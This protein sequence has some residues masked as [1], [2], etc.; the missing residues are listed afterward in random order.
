MM[1]NK[2]KLRTVCI[3]EL[4]L[5]IL[6]DTDL[7][8]MK[9]EGVSNFTFLSNFTSDFLCYYIL[10]SCCDN[11]YNSHIVL[12]NDTSHN[13]LI[14]VLFK[15]F[16]HSSVGKESTCNAG[17]PGSIP[18][19]GRFTGEG[20][21]YPLQ[22]SWASPVAQLV[23]NLPAVQETRVQSLGQEDP[24]EKGMVT[25]SSILAWRIRYTEDPGGLKSMGSQRIGRDWVTNASL[26]TGLRFIFKQLYQEGPWG[27]C[28][29]S[30]FRLENICMLPLCLS[31]MLT[32]FPV[33]LKFFLQDASH[34]SPT[35]C[36][37]CCCR[38][39]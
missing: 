33:G 3:F 22:Y 16:P 28:S 18:E 2:K 7:S 15:G 31:D 36:I 29:L 19:S 17:D 20:V 25:H 14:L 12:C 21:G 4:Q 39:V 35:D 24:L 34:F 11:L 27:L 6:D 26:L 9:F 38:D 5:S 13:R 8:A 37:Q 30:S 10:F 32:G 23:K 1:N